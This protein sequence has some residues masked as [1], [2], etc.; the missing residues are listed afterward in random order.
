MPSAGTD[1]GRGQ[2][3]RAARGGVEEEKNGRR[4]AEGGHRTTALPAPTSG[5]MGR[6]REGKSRGC[7]D[8]PARGTEGEGAADAPSPWSSSPRER[9]R[10]RDDGERNWFF[11]LEEKRKLSNIFAWLDSN[12]KSKRKSSNIF[13]WLDSNEKSKKQSRSLRSRRSHHRWNLFQEI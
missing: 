3:A 11:L 7:W 10:A 12:E 4:R 8:S 2:P 1:G 9:S 5:E 13:A 6:E